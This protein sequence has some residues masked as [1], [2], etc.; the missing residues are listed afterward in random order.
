[1]I[2]LK[3]TNVTIDTGSFHYRC[4]KRYGINLDELSWDKPSLSETVFK[5]LRCLHTQNKLSRFIG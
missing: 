5:Q 2:Y 3:I 1:M 4:H